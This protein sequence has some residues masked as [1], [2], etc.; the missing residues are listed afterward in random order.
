MIG[1]LLPA[2]GTPR[3]LM[4]ATLVNTVGNGA[5]LATGALFLTRS[6]GLTPGQVALG[7]S[8]AAFAGIG[9]S[10]PMGALVDRWGPRHVQVAALLALAGC[11]AGLTRV[12]HLWS[13]ALLACVIAVGDATVKAAT[14]AMIAGAVPPA[15]RVRTRAFIRSTNNAGIA[16]G[17]AAAAVPLLLDSRAGYLAVLIGNTASYLLAA[18]VASRAGQVTRVLRPAGG[19]RLAA[20]RDRPFVAFALVDGVVASLY[21]GLLALALPLWLVTRTHAPAAL[22]SAVLLVNTIGCVTLQV[23]A[24]R[25]VSTA[26]DAV[27]VSRRGALVVAASCVLFGLTAGRSAR[28][29]G[30]LILTAA[31]VHVLG[32]LWLS[33]AT[34]AVAFD[35]APDWAQGQYQGALQTG[36]QIGNMLAPP[37]LTGLVIGWGGPGWIALA[38]LFAVAGLAYPPIVRWG[39][40]QRV[41]TLIQRKAVNG[42]LP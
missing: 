39:L 4:F 7:L 9:L 17:T 28:L 29:A 26:S 19:P 2:P 30:A 15:E 25:G 23:W 42:A 37:L 22:V 1:K 6:V 10:T 20:L 24:S 18:V 13:Y 5:Y 12:H 21:N 27:P 40:R 11:F 31:A 33:S 3:V 41:P 32:E 34:F 16:L 38:V 8:F 35:L 36:R 14:G